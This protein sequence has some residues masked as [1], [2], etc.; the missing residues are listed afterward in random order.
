MSAI[1]NGFAES[2][3]YQAPDKQT[4]EMRSPDGS[5]DI[6]NMMAGLVTAAKTGFGMADALKVAE[7][8]YVDV[9]IHDKQNEAKLNS[10]EQLPTSCKESADALEKNRALFEADGVFDKAM[11]DGTIAK[12]RAYGDGDIR[13]RIKADPSLMSGLVEEYFHCG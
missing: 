5:A 1:A 8:T 3:D 10:L 13:A 6:Y 12:L 4:V 9:N 7:E 2:K 11:I